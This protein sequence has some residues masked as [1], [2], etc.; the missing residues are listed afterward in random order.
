MSR[1][2]TAIVILTWNRLSTL[3]NTIRL[4][5]DYN[6]KIRD[7][8]IIIVD[9][10]ST[11]GTPEFLKRTNY[12]I[13]LNKKNLGAQMGKYIGWNYA[14]KK[15]YDFILFLEDDH[16]CCR[17]V[18]IKYVERYLDKN[19][20]VGIVKLNNKKF[21]KNNKISHLPI[22][23]YKKEKLNGKFKIFKINY[24]FTSNPS[25]FRAS[26]VPFLKSCV[27]PKY[28]PKPEDIDFSKFGF[29][30]YNIKKQKI[31]KERC[32]NNYGVCEKEYMRL[33]ILNYRLTAQIEPFCFKCVIEKR[34]LKWKN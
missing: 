29:E 8:D 24:H 2:R 3:K 23:C 32:L 5:M 18:P 14:F 10:G 31:S 9:N 25:I 21:L 12:N 15:R 7:K 33:F 30:K 22:E 16:P 1:A 17:T 11:D 13:I 4:L 28:K 26:L 34:V 20:D 27:F 19:K 6:T